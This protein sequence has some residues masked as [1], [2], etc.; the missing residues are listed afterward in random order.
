MK[1]A[2]LLGGTFSQV[3]G[4]GWNRIYFAFFAQ[5]DSDETFLSTFSAMYNAHTL[6]SQKIVPLLHTPHSHDGCYSTSSYQKI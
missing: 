4:G 2:A 1:L 6:A 3:K 5:T